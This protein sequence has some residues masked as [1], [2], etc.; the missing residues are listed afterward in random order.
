MTPW[1]CACRSTAYAAGDVAR[2]WSGNTKAFEEGSVPKITR[3]GGPTTEINDEVAEVE[4]GDESSPGISS[5]ASEEKPLKNS[6]T[7]RTG[8]RKPAPTTGNRSAKDPAE[9][10]SA[11]STDGS[12]P[13]TG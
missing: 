9:S 6:A 3:H 12:T 10:A 2:P 5:S 1:G 8:R 7:S 11:A 4:G 13:A